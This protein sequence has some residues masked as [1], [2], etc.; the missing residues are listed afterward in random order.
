MAMLVLVGLFVV[1]SG[2]RAIGWAIVA[3]AAVFLAGTTSKTAIALVPIVL[4]S[5]GLCRLLPGRLLR[6]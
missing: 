1:A 6:A 2:E 5:T 3:G 4:V